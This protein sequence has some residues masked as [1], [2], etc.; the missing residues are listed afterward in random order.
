MRT[1]R[2]EILNSRD[3]MVEALYPITGRM[4]KAYVASAIRDLAAQIN[5]SV[6]SNPLMLRLRSVVSGKSIAELALADSAGLQLDGLYL[7]RRGTGEL[8]CYWPQTSD[9]PAT[10]SQAASWRQSTSSQAMP[11]DRTRMRCVRSMSAMRTST[12]APRRCTCWPLAA[13]AW[14]RGRRAI[15][16]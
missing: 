15:D 3:E 6:D 11:S 12:F 14:P 10:T 4:V 1:I 8:V 9:D 13:T 16:R 7:I 5:R 2:T